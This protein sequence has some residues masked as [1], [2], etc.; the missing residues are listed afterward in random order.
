MNKALS[1]KYLAVFSQRSKPDMRSL[2][3][4]CGHSEGP[5][6]DLI[7][8]VSLHF[9]RAV[10]SLRQ[11]RGGRTFAMRCQSLARSRTENE[12]EYRA[13][14]ENRQIGSVSSR[15]REPLSPLKMDR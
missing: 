13:R 6:R 15:D 12:D 4:S 1:R 2:G 5:V 11:H 10:T 14:L 8:F 3:A 9:D 7:A